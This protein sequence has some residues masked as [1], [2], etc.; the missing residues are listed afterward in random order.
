MEIRAEVTTRQGLRHAQYHGATVTLHDVSTLPRSGRRREV[1]EGDARI[2]R[3]SHQC[4]SL[5]FP[6]PSLARGALGPRQGTFA[7]SGKVA[8]SERDRN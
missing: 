4:P 3:E 2:S 7:A 1:P 6:A 5:T 8:T